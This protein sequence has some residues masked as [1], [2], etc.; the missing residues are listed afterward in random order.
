MLHVLMQKEHS[1]C[2]SGLGA[3]R[4]RQGEAQKYMVVVQDVQNYVD[5]EMYEHLD[6]L[7]P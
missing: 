4:K 1:N 2:V 6:V 3:S 7:I 5:S